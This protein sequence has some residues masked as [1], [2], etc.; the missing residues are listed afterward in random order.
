MSGDF[1]WYV[2]KHPLWQSEAVYGS[3]ESSH[4]DATDT[5]YFWTRRSHPLVAFLMVPERTLSPETRVDIIGA[6]IRNLAS[7]TAT[8]SN[9]KGSVEHTECLFVSF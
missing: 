1:P 5:I 6:M 9:I 4:V 7:S 3:F 8:W 2:K